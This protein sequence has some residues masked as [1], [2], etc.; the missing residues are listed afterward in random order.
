MKQWLLPPDGW[1]A[2]TTAELRPGGKYEHVMIVGQTEEC[3]S[4]GKYTPGQRLPHY[5]EYIEIKP[6]ERLVFTWNSHAVQDSRVTIDLR[7]LGDSTELWLTHELLPTESLR[8]GHSEGWTKA[9]EKL[10]RLVGI[11]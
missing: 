6:P 7:D 10:D 5:G 11:Q 4:N 9:L 1:T 8:Q 2:E 3:C